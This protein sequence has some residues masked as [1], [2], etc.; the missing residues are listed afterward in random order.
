MYTFV[1]DNCSN[2]SSSSSSSG[3]GNDRASSLVVDGVQ[4]AALGHG[5]VGDAVLSHAFL[6]TEAVVDALRK[7]HGWDAGFVRLQQGDFVRDAATNQIADIVQ[8]AAAV[9]E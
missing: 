5:V 2:S 9:A 8:S 4:C 7:C 3:G 1:L 6:G